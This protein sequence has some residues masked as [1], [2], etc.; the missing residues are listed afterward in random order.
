MDLVI[1]GAGQKTLQRYSAMLI[2]TF[3]KAFPDRTIIM[4]EANTVPAGALAIDN[5]SGLQ[6]VIMEIWRQEELIEICDIK[7]ALHA[8]NEKRCRDG[9]KFYRYNYAPL[10]LIV[11]RIHTVLLSIRGIRIRCP[12][13]LKTETAGGRNVHDG[14]ATQHV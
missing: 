14:T 5:L 3:G 4:Q 1:L 12:T 9:W 2:A 11:Y 10:S 6:S 7:Y 13:K 8:I